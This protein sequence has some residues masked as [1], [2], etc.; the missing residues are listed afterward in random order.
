MLVGVPKPFRIDPNVSRAAGPPGAL[1]SDPGRFRELQDRLF[2]RTWHCVPEFQQIAGGGA[3]PATLLEGGLDEPL[4]LVKDP[5]GLRC[6]PNVCTHRGHPI[7]TKPGPA[8]SF[9]CRY[10]GRT[11]DGQGR[12]R[13]MPEFKNVEGFPGPSDDLA[14]IPCETVGPLAFASL[15]PEHAFRS[16]IDPVTRRLDFLSLE[17]LQFDPPSSREYSFDANWALYVDNY[18]EGFHIPFIH[19]ALNAAMEWKQY[20]YELYEYGNLQTAIAKEGDP[21]FEPPQGHPDAGRRV[22]AYYFWLFPCTMLNFYPWGLSLNVVEPLSPSRTRVRFRSFVMNPELR[23]RGAS[24][25]LHQVEMEDEAAVCAVQR[26]MASRFAP[27]IR[28]SPT[29]ELAVHQFH[30]LMAK[31]LSE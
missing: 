9:T 15:D 22:A 27:R 25:D 31:F 30:R 21:C 28:Y 4:F 1:Y 12:C 16:W 24:A 3:A 7:V 20:R 11:F 29:Q 18:L 23:G 17:R 8:D 13:H 10:H 14:P 5:A 19:P 26:G 2:A 6:Y